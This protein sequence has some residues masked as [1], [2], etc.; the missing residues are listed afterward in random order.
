LLL[1]SVSLLGVL[2]YD[3]ENSTVEFF[4]EG[5]LFTNIRVLLTYGFS[6]M[7]G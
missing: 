6:S 4:D 1:E 5:I 7:E 3:K 2:Y